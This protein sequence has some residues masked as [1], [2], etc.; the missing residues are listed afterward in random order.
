MLTAH[1]IA[2]ADIPAKLESITFGYDI[3]VGGAK[4]HTLFIA[5]D[6]D[7]IGTVTDTHHPNGASNPNQFFVFAFDPAEL[8][9][10]QPQRLH[11]GVCRV[12]RD[13]HGHGSGHGHGHDD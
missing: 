1:G 8:P 13:G 11:E 7:F 2:P 12:D 6:N 9:G 4:K 3:T 10:F 5:N